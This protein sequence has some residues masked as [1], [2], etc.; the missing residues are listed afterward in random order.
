MSDHINTLFS[1]LLH[2]GDK[3]S[4][5]KVIRNFVWNNPDLDKLDAAIQ[6]ILSYFAHDLDF[7]VSNPK[8]RKEV[9]SYYGDDRLIL[10]ESLVIEKLARIQQ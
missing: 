1:Q 3:A 8:W 2:E 7:Y 10:E 4:T 6:D 9:P 5:I